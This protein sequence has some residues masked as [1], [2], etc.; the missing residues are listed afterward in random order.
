MA[1]VLKVPGHPR[2]EVGAAAHSRDVPAPLEDEAPDSLPVEARVDGGRLDEKGPQVAAREE[3]LVDPAVAPD[4]L[5][6]ALGVAGDTVADR[7]AHGLCTATLLLRRS[8]A[9]VAF[10]AN[11]L[12][13][14][15]RALLVASLTLSGAVA[16]SDDLVDLRASFKYIPPYTTPP[17]QP[18]AK[19]FSI[20]GPGTI[21][22]TT[23]LSPW[24]RSSEPVLFRSLVP[25]DGRDEGAWTGHVPGVERV[26]SKSTPE[27]WVDGADLTIVTE[28]RTRKARPS[29]EIGLFPST[30]R[31]GDGS[32]EQHANSVHVTI[33]CQPDA[34]TPAAGASL[35]GRWLDG[36]EPITL[37]VHG[38][39]VTGDYPFRD[40]RLGGTASGRRFTGV[41]RQSESA[42]RSA[43]ARDG[44]FYWGRFDLALD[45]DR[46]EGRWGYCDGPLEAPW[47]WT[48]SR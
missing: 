22:M 47:S 35:A 21:R 7:V 1:G 23:T 18:V 44:T 16:L 17:S 45:G 43:D 14:R 28:Y 4:D 15:F 3:A 30:F 6:G 33:E 13:W 29:L 26:S 36:Q 8:F 34:S 11:T 40:G 48:R 9:V 20:P 37:R 38:D 25:V 46:L 41:W 12:S 39:S 24:F 27:R 31:H 19:G 2:A 5:E 10:V 42:R 32:V